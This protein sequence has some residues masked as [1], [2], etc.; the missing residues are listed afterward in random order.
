MEVTFKYKFSKNY[1]VFKLHKD[2]EEVWMED[3]YIDYD[4][5]KI[6]FLLLR[7]AM[8]KFTDEEYKFFV[9]TVLKEDLVNLDKNKW[10]IIDTDNLS[11][12][13]IIKC[14][15]SEALYN[16]ASSLGFSEN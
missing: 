7:N 6:F 14:P 13:V 2:I 11:P 16:I 12:T 15:I 3:V 9:Q 1:I 8:E 10:N 5:P 4:H